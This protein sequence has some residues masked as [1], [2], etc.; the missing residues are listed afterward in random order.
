MVSNLLANGLTHGEPGEPVRIQAA[1]TA[2][3]LEVSVANG[4]RPIPPET[5]E[6]LFQPFFRGARVLRA[7]RTRARRNAF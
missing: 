5:M 2:G 3:E 4:G 6:R 7:V 1:T